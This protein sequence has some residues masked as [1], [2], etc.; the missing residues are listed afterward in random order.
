M[1]QIYFLSIATNLLVGFLLAFEKKAL[2]IKWFEDKKIRLCIGIVCFIT[3]IV[4]MFVVASNISFLGDFIPMVTGIAGGFTLLLEYY[5]SKTAVTLKEGSFL[6]KIF[7]IN[8]KAIGIVCLA[9]AGLHFVFP[10]VIF[11]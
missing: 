2:E 6:Q 10:N 11:F 8:K 5:L 4:K 7:I 3:G 1:L 9:A